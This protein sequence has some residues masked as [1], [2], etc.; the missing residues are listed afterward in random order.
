MVSLQEETLVGNTDDSLATFLVEALSERL[1]NITITNLFR[2]TGGANRETWSFDTVDTD[3]NITE[4]ILQLDRAGL[5]RLIGT[6]AKESQI[7]KKAAKWKVPVAAVVISSDVPNPLGRS[8]TVT[9]RIQGETIARKILRDKEWEIARS[10]LVSNCA[11]ALAAIHAIPEE[12]LEELALIK[13]T[14]SLASL[15]EIYDALCDPHPTFDLAI[16]WLEANR[17]EPLK[18]C[19]VHG[20]FRLGNLLIDEDGLRAV[21]DWEIAHLGDPAEDLGWMCVR[22]WRFGGIGKVAGL[23]EYEDFINA[24]EKS[25]GTRVPLKTLLWWEIFGTLRWGVICLQMGGDFRAGR[26]TSIEMAT[27]GRRVAENEYDL[28]SALKEQLYE[29]A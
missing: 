18:S 5:D 3:E 12:E 19:L 26:T 2:L 7:L 17:P 25:S 29:H 10:K 6:C 11:T 23:D 28:L 15:V 4:L 24:Y 21:L 8:F 20:D 27:I 14:D 9:H 16:R 22:A 13:V 1:G